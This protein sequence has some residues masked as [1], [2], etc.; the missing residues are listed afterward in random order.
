MFSAELRSDSSYPRLSQ[1]F[2][3]YEQ[4]WKKLF[5][6][7]GPHTRVFLHSYGSSPALILSSIIL[8]DS[9]SSRCFQ[10]FI[11]FQILSQVFK[12][13]LMS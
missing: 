7:F 10:I 11:Y 1:M 12:R 13:V 4:P 5:E 8:K 6:D 3:E 9:F 2:I